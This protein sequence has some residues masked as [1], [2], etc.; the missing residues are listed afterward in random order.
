MA[1]RTTAKL[2]LA[3]AL[4]LTT[5]VAAQDIGMTEDEARAISGALEK[6]V[7]A[8]QAGQWQTAIDFLEPLTRRP[9]APP[10]VRALLGAAY[11]EADR[12]QQALAVLEP[13]LEA[14]ISDPAVLYNAGRAALAVGRIAD[15]ERFLEQAAQLAPG[16]PAARTLGLIR[17]RQGRTVEAYQLLRPLALAD[18]NDRETRLAATALALDLERAVEAEEM[19]SDLPQSDPRVRLL[20]GRLLLLQK[21]VPGARAMVEPIL[22]QELPARLAADARRL[23]ADIQIELGD[24]AA[25]RELLGDLVR[26][27]ITAFKLSQAEYQAGD[28]DAAIKTL[29]PFREPLLAS[30]DQ[31]VTPAMRRIR[32]SLARELGR[33]L[34]AAGRH[35]ESVELLELSAKLDPQVKQ[36]WQSLGQALGAVGRRQEAEQALD[37]FR[38]VAAAEGNETT[39]QNRQSQGIDDATGRELAKAWQ[40][41]GEGRF[42]AALGVVRTELALAPEDPR[43]R[44][45]E[46]RILLLLG[47]HEEALSAVERA[48]G[49]APTSAD[50]WYQRGAVKLAAKDLAGAEQDL[51]RALEINASHTAAMN[52]L[53]VLLIVRGD[54]DEARNLLERVLEVNPADRGAAQN[55]ERLNSG[56]T[57]NAGTG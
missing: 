45:A 1:T 47:R 43:P 14:Q 39:R 7:S 22:G 34:I 18:P 9:D 40:L 21:D 11:T 17:G 44:L 53:A 4:A 26:D 36:T 35:A 56:G 27:P 42:E 19:L 31:E 33:Y 3:L 25:A 48:L 16:S 6:A 23:L 55:L 57:R 49:K 24:A 46:S 38:Q 5:T 15:G 12:P 2:A 37:R 28:V 51:R 29:G 50:A 54:R 41:V 20:W 8:L 52:D 30:A 32:A 10:K 13:L